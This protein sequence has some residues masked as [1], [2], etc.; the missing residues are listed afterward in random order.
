MLF[1]SFRSRHASSDQLWPPRLGLLGLFLLMGLTFS[2]WLARIPTVKAELGI[3]TADLGVVL[4]AGSV[5]AL[6]TVAVA[7]AVLERVGGRAALAV[8]AVI[9]AAAYLLLGLGPT[10]GSVPILTVGVLLNGIA[11]ALANVPQSVETAGIERRLGRTVIPQFH[12]AFSVG[13][14]VGSLLGAACA[15]VGVPL[16]AQ[17]GVTAAVAT[18]WRFATFPVVVHDTA[19][20]RAPRADGGVTVPAT[21]PDVA[22]VT[23][24]TRRARL[25]TALGAWREPRTVLVGLVVLAAALSEGSANDWLSLAVVD[26]FGR[27]EAVGGVVFGTFVAA[28]TVVRILG[29]RL[30][31]RHGRVAVLRVSGVVSLV[32][33][34]AFGLAP[35]FP[36]AVAGVVAWGVGAALAVPI[37]IAAAS[38]DPLRAA[39]RVSVVSS[40]SS[41]ASIAAPPLLGLAAE[42]IGARHALV[43]IAFAMVLSVC[44]AAQVAPPRRR[45]DDAAPASLAV[46]P[47][48]GAVPPTDEVLHPAP[49]HPGPP[50]RL[51]EEVLA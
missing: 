3:S 41:L 23:R 8:A 43:L 4:L 51:P 24:P 26:G 27:T 42:A 21:G 32:G 6:A 45:P 15:A 48:A 1:E 20:R 33:L 30:I 36:L 44:L 37:G 14:V 18:A 19:R 28:M 13:A 16:L 46:S 29:T 2:S 17:F 34:L 9:S 22:P 11:F 50:A 49:S 35:S 47:E 25:A 5:G 31:D 7:G 12:A 10:V 39:G 40:F 38:D